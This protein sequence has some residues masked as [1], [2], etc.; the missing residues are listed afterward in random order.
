MDRTPTA[1]E[2]IMVFKRR[3]KITSTFSR[4]VAKYPHTSAFCS[5]FFGGML[6]GRIIL[7]LY[8]YQYSNLANV[9]EYKVKEDEWVTIHRNRDVSLKYKANGCAI[10]DDMFVTVRGE[11]G[12]YVELFR[13]TDL[14]FNSVQRNATNHAR[15]KGHF[16]NKFLPVVCL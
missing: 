6:S 8:E 2:M 14:R 16:M 11:E 5:T 13:L 12:N 4:P 7:F 10:N 3:G 9:Y 15:K 1:P